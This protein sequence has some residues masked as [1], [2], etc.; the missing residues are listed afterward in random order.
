MNWDTG[1]WEQPAPPTSVYFQPPTNP[2]S[3][4]KRQDY[5]PSRIG[6]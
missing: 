3:K 1:F 2:K 4:M 5:Y 6:D